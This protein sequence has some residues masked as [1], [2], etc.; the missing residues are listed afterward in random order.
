MPGSTSAT[1]LLHRFGDQPHRA[2]EA[3]RL[4]LDLLSEKPELVLVEVCELDR[5]EPA[6]IDT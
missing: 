3:L 4:E 6:W 5:R 1:A 2:V